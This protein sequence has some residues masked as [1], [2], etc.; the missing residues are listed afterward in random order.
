MTQLLNVS[1]SGTDAGTTAGG[2]EGRAGEDERREGIRSGQKND[3]RIK[4]MEKEK[5]EESMEG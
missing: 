3:E 2:G 1:L 4:M 5:E